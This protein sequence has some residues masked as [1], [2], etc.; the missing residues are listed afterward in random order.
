MIETDQKKK[1]KESLF[2]KPSEM[3]KTVFFHGDLSLWNR[4]SRKVVFI[5]MVFKHFQYL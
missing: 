5:D 3:L 4:D 1:K 2:N